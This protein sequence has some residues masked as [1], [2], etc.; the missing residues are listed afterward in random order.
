M[1][2]WHAKW[3][4]HVQPERREVIWETPEYPNH[5]HRADVL[6]PTGHVIEVQHSSIDVIEVAEREQFY[7]TCHR[8]LVWIVDAREFWQ[9]QIE[10]FV[11]G[12]EDRELVGAIRE[13]LSESGESGTVSFKWSHPRHAW[14]AANCPV[15]LDPGRMGD[16][17]RAFDGALFRVLDATQGDPDR[18]EGYVPW[19]KR[20]HTPD[21][22]MPGGVGAFIS[23]Q[24]F[25]SKYKLRLPDKEQRDTSEAY[26][27]PGPHHTLSQ[28]NRYNA[29]H[30]RDHSE[31]NAA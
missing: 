27:D 16:N 1:T 21:G 2:M 19:D 6:A 30:E 4:S 8:G 26:P 29:Q 17:T 13:N 31:G 24:K 23:A 7:S 15:Y 18:W 14:I 11:P 10:I 25:R 28:F 3:C 22:D 12:M 20:T 5:I 9:S